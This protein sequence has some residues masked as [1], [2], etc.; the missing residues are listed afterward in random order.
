MTNLQVEKK[1]YKDTDLVTVKVDVENTGEREGKEV[2]QLYVR[3][4]VSSVV[5]PVKSLRA[6]KKIDL[7]AK[8]KKS[9]V[10]QFPIAELYIRDND[11][12]KFIEA[13]DFEI[14][15][16]NASDNIL[17]KD[18]INVGSLASSS[19]NLNIKEAKREKGQSIK[20]K[21]TIRDI[22]A[23]L[24]YDAVVYSTLL[25]KEVGKSDN[26]GN[27]SIEVPGNDILVFKKK[28]IYHLK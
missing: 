27:Y 13:G 11:Y 12:N 22:Q 19:T 26:K 1:N 10:L 15:V 24:I 7:K 3:D 25:N 23:T 8:E 14:Q 17:L 28:A 5:T 4:M 18:T 9:V 21:G 16:G 6:F 20:V 2:V